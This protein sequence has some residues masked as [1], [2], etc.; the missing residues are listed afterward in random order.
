MG[1]MT[2]REFVGVGGALAAGFGL[3]GWPRAERSE[4]FRSGGSDLTPELILVNGNV[5]TVD[6][7]QPRAEA[8]AVRNGR[9]IAVG[10]NDDIRN[11]ASPETEV[12]DAGRRTVTPGFIDAHCHPTGVEELFMVNLID[13]RTV[14]RLQEMLAEEAKRQPPEHW[15]EGVNYDD[16]KVVD[17]ST[18]EYRR[19]TRRDLDEVVPDNPCEVSHRGGH[20]AWYNTRALEMAGVLEET[21]EIEGGRFGRDENGELNGLV[22]EEARGV[23]EGIGERKEFSREDRARGVA[24]I[25]ELMTAAGIT[26]VHQTGGGQRNLTALQ[27]AYAAGD[28]RWRMH[29]FVSG[30]DESYERLREAGMRSGVGDRWLRIEGVKFYSDGSCSGRTMAMSTPYAGRPDDFGILTM[31]QEE[32]HEAVERAHRDGWRIGIHANGDVAIDNVLNAYERVQRRWP[33]EDPRHRIEHCTLVNPFLLERIRD[34]GSIPTPFWTYCHFHGDKWGAYGEERT[35]WMWA[36]RSF[37]DYDIPVAG[38]SDYTPGPYDPMMAIQSMVTRK[39]TKG[40]VWGPNQRVSVDEA[41]K[42]GTLHGAYASFDE[43]LKGSIT[44][45]KLADWVM[46]A[47]DP[48]EVDPDRIKEIE[49]LRTDVGGETMHEA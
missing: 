43:D 13:V 38:A 35:R 2:R 36:H 49:V 22:E 28:M 34:S 33:R 37:L 46:L 42:I 25:S 4:R 39:D 17:E 8:F 47:E 16:T 45:G 10:S 48:H 41:L 24:H 3:G 26:T 20:I 31:T 19:I 29:F 14:G 30:E 40:R 1:E 7:S 12:V 6:Q 5:Y 32:V 9:F 21:P 15:V 23:F 11:L 44:A 27:D 18:G